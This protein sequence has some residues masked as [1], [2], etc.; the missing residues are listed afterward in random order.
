MLKIRGKRAN[1]FLLAQG[2][3]RELLLHNGFRDRVMA[4]KA[5]ARVNH[6]KVGD[7]SRL[8]AS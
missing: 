5:K 4:I 8:L 2:R 7:T 6:P 3:S 1:L